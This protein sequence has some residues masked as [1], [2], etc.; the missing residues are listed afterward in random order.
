MLLSL[1]IRRK[2]IHVQ[3]V[4]MGTW[5]EYLLQADVAWPQHS[6]CQ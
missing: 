6:Y 3:S 4:R 2:R 5:R 1:E